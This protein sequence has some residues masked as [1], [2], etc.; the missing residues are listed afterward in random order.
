[1]TRTCHLHLGMN[2]A[3]STAVQS[4]FRDYADPRTRYLKLVR[5][6]HTPA[7]ISIFCEPER[8]DAWFRGVGDRFERASLAQ[9]E[10]EVTRDRRD[11][12]VSGEGFPQYLNRAEIGA[13]TTYLAGHFDRLS[14]LVYVREPKSYM[15]SLLQQRVKSGRTGLDM[16][17]LLPRYR[18]R[19]RR[20]DRGLGA[21]RISYVHFGRDSLAG[22][23]VR[24][25]FA[26][27]LGLHWDGDEADEVNPSLSLEAFAVLYR[28]RQFQ[29][30][31]GDVRHGRRDTPHWMFQFGSRRFELDE[32]LMAP[33]LASAEDD[34]A[35][36]EGRM[37]RSFAPSRPADG[38][39]TIA[40]ED[41]IAAVAA[42]ALPAFRDWVASFPR[43][44]RPRAQLAE[45]AAAI[46]QSVSRST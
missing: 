14:G 28:Y 9:L 6:N 17:E 37:G 7:L 35:W 4:A 5:A 24:R 33:A 16:A 36:V 8:R 20:W 18:R 39:A 11:L 19:F 38:V 45:I 3:G 42:D 29:D 41:D 10:E 2:K 21:A 44:S 26:D 23:D 32:A 22:G 30:A 27:R 1:M 15:R 25:D 13:M 34:I 46:G 12:I 40:T 31:S 43:L